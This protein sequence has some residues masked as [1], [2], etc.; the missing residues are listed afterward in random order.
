MEVYGIDNNFKI[1]NYSA[2][3]MQNPYLKNPVVTGSVKSA[4]YQTRG[5]DQGIKMMTDVLEKKISDFQAI[6]KN[7]ILPSEDLINLRDLITQISSL[8]DN[9]NVNNLGDALRELKSLGDENYASRQ[10]LS[11][12][13]EMHKNEQSFAIRSLVFSIYQK[14]YEKETRSRS[15]DVYY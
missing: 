14:G 15:V 2:Q 8:R 11:K 1:N 5:S 6:D 13:Q 12:A 3:N 4:N 9:L 7:M 10:Q